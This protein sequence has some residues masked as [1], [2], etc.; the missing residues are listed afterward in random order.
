M[1]S[2]FSVREDHINNLSP[3]YCVQ[4]F[5]ELLHSD[6]R[7]LKLSISKVNFTTKTVPDGGIDA[8][9]EDGISQEGDLIIDPESF[10]QIKSGETF[11]SWQESEIKEE[12][13]H[14]KPPIKQNL[15]DEVQRCF[16]RNGTYIL[17][18]MKVQLSTQ[19]KKQSEKNLINVLT[20]CG[21]DNPKVKV[22]GQDKIIGT[23]ASYPSLVLRLTR[24]D[25]PVFQSHQDWSNNHDMQRELVLG[26]KQ[27]D[28]IKI[29][30][31]ALLDDSETVHVHIYGETGVGKTRLV[32]ESTRISFLCPLVIY[33]SSPKEF[34]SKSLLNE[35][36]ADNKLHC[37]LIIDECYYLDHLNIWNKLASLGSRI[38]LVTMSHEYRRVDETTKQNEAPNLDES[39][40]KEIIKKYH[41]D[42]ILAGRLSRICN[43]IPRLA[44]MIGWDL[45]NNPKEILRGSQD[46]FA[47]FD[48]Y[49]NQGEDPLS[50]HVLQR[51]RILLTIS[52]FKKFGSITYF[53]NEFK[54]V[55]AIIEE[56]DP[57]ITLPIFLEHVKD[58]QDRKILQGQETLY[59][60]PKG[61]HLWLWME[62]WES[63]HASITFEKLIQIIHPTLRKW[64]FTMFQ[65]A[66]NS[67]ATKTVVQ[68]LFKDGGPLLNSE[69]IKTSL[70]AE[71]FHSLSNADPTTAT[72]YLE[73]TMGTWSN[74]EL[75][76]FSIGRRSVIYGLERI[77][78]EPELF[79]RGGTLLRS[80]AENE[81][82]EWSNNATGLF[83]SLFSLGIGYASLTKT[84]PKMRLAL[85]K[86]TLC[87]DNENRRNLGLKA[88]EFALKT[89]DFLYPS[90]LP[91][92]ELRVE[93]KGWEPKINQDWA[94]AYK[95]VIELIIERL[96]T[97]TNKD[98]QKC[99]SM[100]S[101]NSRWL[102]HTFSFMGEYIVE[103]LYQIKKFI[104]KET[105]LENIIDILEF[106]KDRLTP[107]TKS[108]LETLQI[109]IIGTDYSSLLKR[110]V[111]MDIMLDLA[112]KDREK[113]RVEHIQKLVEMSLN[114][115]K[116]KP[117]LSW[118]TTDNAR[119]GY[120]FGQELAK[121][122][123][124]FLLLPLLL[125]E[126][127]KTDEKGTGFFLS[128]Y[129]VI[130]FEKNQKK[131]LQI[132][133]E[134]SQDPELIRFFT[135]IAWRSGITDEIGLLILNL[136]KSQKIKID[137]LDKFT[138]GGA[139]NRLSEKV[140]L[141]W[142]EYMIDTNEQKTIFSA[143]SL[144]DAFFVYRA[145][146]T[147]NPE[148]TLKL[149]THDVFMGRTPVRT[150]TMV[151]Y[152]WNEIGLRFIQQYPD[153][154]LEFADRLLA[155]MDSES[156][157][158]SPHSQSLE[159][160]DTVASRLP[161]EVWDLMTKYIALPFDK[162]GY[163]IINWMRG[164]LF[165]PSNNFLDKVDF[166][167]ILDWIDN[168]PHKLAPYIIEHVPPILTFDSL[169][170]K[171]LVKYG[172]EKSVKISLV[173]NFSTEGFSGSAST[174]F[175]EKKEKLLVYKEHDDNENVKNWI[176]FYV[177]CLDEDINREKLQE[178]RE[179]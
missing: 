50:T 83:A 174:H 72:D 38:K 71:L 109:E 43:G 171:L 152:H 1:S 132:M 76:D 139:V 42:D 56:I 110:Y 61:L 177:K 37:I 153:E 13:L 70:G 124:D 28:F 24:K 145:E 21:I 101:Q 2:I 36:I 14:G 162:R 176:D 103:K 48:R 113:E 66:G 141:E 67:D 20:A 127:R 165:A 97:F 84:P 40:I 11:S 22:W 5:G 34:L 74:K 3:E 161:D 111:G 73:R 63:Y 149:L 45:K 112:N 128:G 158:I 81:N 114:T 173:A 93:Q 44:H 29:I 26:K 85:L 52:L 4:L 30:Q 12:L 17:V 35:I 54:S 86:E 142:I 148:I 166:Q 129:L 168:N 94:D 58:L 25:A 89:E 144:Y 79:T 7:R 102:F 16:E 170:R 122:D 62:W 100:I 75:C 179:F 15:G 53:P 27:K 133:N 98:K 80:L 39:Q 33:C 95:S 51:K 18:C 82:E 123:N 167:K 92:D 135:E 136:I 77:V 116:L 49:I 156:S 150:Y 143:I 6:A 10:Y 125:D 169:A 31:E 178:E 115:E 160:L 78:F 175:Q 69:F 121:K 9:I 146:K 96:Q 8:S 118:L 151:D 107:E 47:F 172:T 104:D 41:D 157:L 159:V 137:E 68:K 108:K 59:I 106:E 131:W 87:S 64:F 140:V 105:L 32:L 163:A 134:I 90:E 23:I 57:S 88:C 60:S 154:S 46:V 147:L 19:Q 65:Y 138:L 99:A 155:S 126:Q 91:A 120:V 55:H 130:I 164:N 117:E 119:Y